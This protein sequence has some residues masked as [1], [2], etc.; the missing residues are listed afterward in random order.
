MVYKWRYNALASRI[1]QL[2]ELWCSAASPTILHGPITK[3]IYAILQFLAAKEHVK[4]LANSRNCKEY[5]TFCQ[6]DASTFTLPF[7]PL[8]HTLETLLKCRHAAAIICSICVGHVRLV[9]ETLLVKLQAQVPVM[10]LNLYYM[11]V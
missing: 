4:Y 9:V 2:P 1:Q 6:H 10:R 11:F 5:S 3:Q 7:S 8:L